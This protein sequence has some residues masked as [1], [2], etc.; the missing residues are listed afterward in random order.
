VRK[1]D[2]RRILTYGKGTLE[3]LLEKIAK[4]RGIYK[5]GD[6]FVRGMI[7]ELL[8]REQG[9]GGGGDR[10]APATSEQIKLVASTIGVLVEQAY[11]L[12]RRADIKETDEEEMKDINEDEPISEDVF[13]DKAV[14]MITTGCLQD[15]ELREMFEQAGM[16]LEVMKRVIEMPET[17][18]FARDLGFWIV[19]FFANESTRMEVADEREEVTEV[20]VP[21]E[22][23]EDFDSKFQDEFKM[24]KWFN[25]LRE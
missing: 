5:S 22:N 16:G 8:D 18:Q 24:E 10:T 11:S 12:Y 21:D 14:G 13:S 20:N 3:D 6:D 4:G 15:P 17:Q 25:I 19:N 7:D 2:F 1:M 9:E 23:P